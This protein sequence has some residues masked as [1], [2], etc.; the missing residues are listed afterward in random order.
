MGL[1]TALELFVEVSGPDAIRLKNTGPNE[2]TGVL[3]L[4][5]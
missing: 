3:T 2:R 1:D 4:L 5:W